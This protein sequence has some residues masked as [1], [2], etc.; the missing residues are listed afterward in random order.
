MA[1]L[2]TIS[3]IDAE[4]ARIELSAAQQSAYNNRLAQIEARRQLAASA[5]EALPSG[6]RTRNSVG[7]A[8]NRAEQV[9]AIEQLRDQDVAK[10]ETPTFKQLKARVQHIQV[11]SARKAEL[12]QR[13]EELE[14]Q[15]KLING[16]AAQEEALG[17]LA[18]D[19]SLCDDDAEL[20]AG[21]PQG[22]GKQKQ[23]MTEKAAQQKVGR[24][25]TAAQRRVGTG[26][27]GSGA[28]KS[29]RPP[30]PPLLAAEEDDFAEGSEQDVETAALRRVGIT[31][32]ISG[33]AGGGRA[34]LRAAPAAPA[35]TPTAAR[36]PAV[37]RADAVSDIMQGLD[38]D[39]HMESILNTTPAFKEILMGAGIQLAGSNVPAFQQ[40]LQKTIQALEK[41]QR[42]QQELAT[43]SALSE[44]TS[45]ALRGMALAQKVTELLR[46]EQL[47]PDLVRAAGGSFPAFLEAMRHPRPEVKQMLEGAA[48]LEQIKARHRPLTAGGGESRY[49]EEPAL[50]RQRP[51]GLAPGRGDV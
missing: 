23:Q 12:V 20:G 26:A 41:E 37:V 42:E 8:D 48:L 31:A 45:A 15:L 38:K 35:P 10:L 2:S 7:A 49:G 24:G 1:L 16:G 36:Q 40:H 17:E 46:F 9:A 44:R 21:Q 19:A 43:C 51:Y 39:M 4:L 25:K 34:G 5:L 14:K 50:K 22:R 13:K 3:A 11:L 6:R 27:V 28:A 47:L 33:P 30:L 29:A 18:L 32:G